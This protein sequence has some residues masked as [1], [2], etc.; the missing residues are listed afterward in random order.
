MNLSLPC[1]NTEEVRQFDEVNGLAEVN[2]DLGNL[3]LYLSLRSFFRFVFDDGN[4]QKTV[5]FKIRLV[6]YV[7]RELLA[8]IQFDTV[9]HFSTY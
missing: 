3:D 9:C 5:G 6:K 4:L 7:T 1:F 2:F 8:V